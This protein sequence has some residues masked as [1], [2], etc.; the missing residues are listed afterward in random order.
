MIIILFYKQLH[1]NIIIILIIKTLLIQPQYDTQVHQSV[2]SLL[3]KGILAYFGVHTTNT[4]N[5]VKSY[6]ATF[7]LPYITSAMAVNMTNQDKGYDLYIRPYYVRAILDLIRHYSW[8]EVYY[9]YS[10]NEGEVNY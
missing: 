3:Q 6:S 4:L 1:N 8:K 10:S 5:T 7:N 9:F 2:C